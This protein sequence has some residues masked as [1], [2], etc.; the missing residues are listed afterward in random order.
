[1]P[2][3]NNATK[4]HNKMTERKQMPALDLCEAAGAPAHRHRPPPVIHPASLLAQS[5]ARRLLVALAATGALWL[6]VVWAI[7]G[8]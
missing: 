6:G 5:A 1:M 7:S 8:Q 3:K 4:L 2:V